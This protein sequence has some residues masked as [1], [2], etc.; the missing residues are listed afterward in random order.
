MIELV[1]LTRNELNSALSVDFDCLD[2]L[3][4]QL[5]V[6]CTDK[7][8]AYVSLDGGRIRTGF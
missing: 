5:T 4:S 2:L 8:V 7:L 1:R 6:L 3:T